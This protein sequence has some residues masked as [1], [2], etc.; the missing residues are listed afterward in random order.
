MFTI[1]STSYSLR[2]DYVLFS[3]PSPKATSYGIH[4]FRTW[5]QNYGTLFQNLLKPLTFMTSIQ[6]LD[7]TV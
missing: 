5:F 3:L 7:S 1:R 4:S 6:A 2:G